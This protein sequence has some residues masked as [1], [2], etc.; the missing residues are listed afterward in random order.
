MIAIFCRYYDDFQELELYPKNMFV[1]VKSVEEIRGVIFTGV[2]QFNNLY[3]ADQAII[4]AFHELQ[5][6]QPEL[7]AINA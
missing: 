3:E 1:R 7:F 2:I 6:S 4:D 5:Y